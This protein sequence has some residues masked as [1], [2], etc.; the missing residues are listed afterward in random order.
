MTRRLFENRNL[1]WKSGFC[2]IFPV[3]F[4]KY[5]KYSPHLI[6]PT[7]E[8]VDSKPLS[9]ATASILGQP[10]SVGKINILTMLCFILALVV[11]PATADST[12]KENTLKAVYSFS[13]GKF[14]RWPKSKLNDSKN[15]L[16]FCIFGKN[17]FGQSILDAFEGKRVKGK[18]LHV[19]LFESGLLS[20]DALPDCHILFIS[21]SEKLR[22]QHIL[23]TLQYQPIL[24]VSDIEGFSRYGG[25][26][27]LIKSGD[28]I[29]FEINPDAINRAGLSISSKLFELAKAV[30]TTES[31]TNN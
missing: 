22:F 15:T 24:T 6:E 29:Q 21:Q 23:N 11:V 17:P 30:R 19:E 26:I 16:G 20:D 5:S 4:V 1:L 7:I 2:P 28:R 14:A 9:L 3:K 8:M 27:T 31:I 13:F 25:M 12:I 10:P 18:I